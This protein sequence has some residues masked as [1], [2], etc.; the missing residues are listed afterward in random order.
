MEEATQ[1]GTFALLEVQMFKHPAGYERRTAA[2]GALLAV[3]IAAAF[4]AACGSGSDAQEQQTPEGIVVSFPSPT[5]EITP[6]PRNT[7]TPTI[8]P[9]PS[10]LKVCADNPDP[11]RPELLQVEEPKPGQQVKVP[12]HVRGWG[13][14]IG[15]GD[16]GVALA[17]VNAKQEVTQVLDLPPQPRNYRIAPPGLQITDNTKPFAA[18]IV[19]NNIKEPTAYCLW[20][21]QETTASGVPKGVVQVPVIVV[22]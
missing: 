15:L 10:P 20:V 14:T 13:S 3:V 17:V 19:I 7:P 6:R 18:D 5:G 11:A 1:G 21:Y 16:K 4:V 22:P 8:T 2:L 12:F 9:S